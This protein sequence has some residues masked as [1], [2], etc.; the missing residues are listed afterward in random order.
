[1]ENNTTAPL[2]SHNSA[3]ADVR[4]A[5]PADVGVGDQVGARRAAQQQD[6]VWCLTKIAQYV[7]HGRQVGLTGV[8]HMQIDLLHDVGDVGPCERQVL[9]SSYNAPEL[10]GILNRM[11][12][13]PNQL[14][15]Q[16]CMTCSPP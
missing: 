13:V 3:T 5:S 6:E 10:R 2:R 16:V 15:L 8:M 12:R 11:P 14:R 4:E 1:V 7:L 9:E